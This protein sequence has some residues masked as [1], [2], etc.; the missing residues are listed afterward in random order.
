MAFSVPDDVILKIQS[1]RG[2]HFRLSWA[3]DRSERKDR[4]P[5]DGISHHLFACMVKKKPQNLFIP[6]PEDFKSSENQ[7]VAKVDSVTKPPIWQWPTATGWANMMGQPS[8]IFA[9]RDAKAK[10]LDPLFPEPLSVADFVRFG[11]FSKNPFVVFLVLWLYLS[12]E[13]MTW[14]S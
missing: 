5:C 4:C 12:M 1:L 11:L 2:R 6:Q 3:V 10:I 13:T 8:C 9:S 7:N 14:N